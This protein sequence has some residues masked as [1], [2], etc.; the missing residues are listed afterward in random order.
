MAMSMFAVYGFLMLKPLTIV[1][2]DDEPLAAGRLADLAGELPNCR[3]LAQA[4]N[5]ETPVVISAERSVKYEAV[6]RVMVGLQKAG[7]QRVG[8]SVKQGT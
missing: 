3:V 2:V 4:G 7:V 8:L 6:V 5:A 1:V